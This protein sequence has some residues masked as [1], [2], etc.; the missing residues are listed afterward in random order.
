MLVGEDPH[1]PYDRPPPSKAVLAGT[2]PPDSAYLHPP[3]WYADRQVELRP[4]MSATRLDPDGH[5]LT[6]ADS[7]NLA[8]DRLLIAGLVEDSIVCDEPM[9]TSA[10][11]VFAAGDVGRRPPRRRHNLRC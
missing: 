10:P 2:D 7:T 4:G 1:L 11:D 3:D 8:W 5:R 9:H 6:L